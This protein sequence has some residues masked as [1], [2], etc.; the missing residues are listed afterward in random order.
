MSSKR[1]SAVA[2]AAAANEGDGHASKKR[3]IPVRV[4]YICFVDI[5]NAFFARYNQVRW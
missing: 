2:A 5:C 1:K 3:K 4:L